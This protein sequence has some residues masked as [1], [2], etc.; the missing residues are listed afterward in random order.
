MGKVVSGQA[1]MDIFTPAATD[2]NEAGATPSTSSDGNGGPRRSVFRGF[3]LDGL[4]R[5][6]QMV[7]FGFL[8]PILRLLRGEAPRES[9]GE[10]RVAVRT[11]WR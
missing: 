1:N 8:N 10:V 4:M 6:L 9:A 11:A 3:S 5:G 7:G 2:E